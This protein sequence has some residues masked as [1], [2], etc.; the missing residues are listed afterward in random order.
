MLDQTHL[1]AL[2]DRHIRIDQVIPGVRKMITQDVVRFIRPAPGMNFISYAWL[3]E[4]A[5]D[6]VIQKQVDYFLKYD[7]PFTWQ[8]MDHDQPANLPERLLRHGFAGDDDPSAVMLLDLEAC[9]PELLQPI[10]A[11]IR[12]ISNMAGLDD[13][14]AI[15]EKVWGGS[16]AWLKQRLGS[17]LEIPGYL[18]VYVVYKDNH[19]ASAAWTY[20]PPHNPFANLYGGA[21]LP[22][23]RRSGLYTAL[24]AY[25]AQEALQ[26]ER[27][28]LM[29][30]C[31]QNSRP[32]VARHGFHFLA[33]QYDYEFQR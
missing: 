4:S 21:T 30:G 27:R 5:A 2:Y 6:K 17:H 19:P 32:I 20:F 14:V 10:Q 28:F 3:E 26:R 22:D 9:P 23:H 18:S 33:H 8:F 1:L 12:Q 24:L 31:N 16:F 15:E 29:I 13:V 25:R 11:D 7:Q